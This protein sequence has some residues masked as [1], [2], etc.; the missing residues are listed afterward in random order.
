MAVTTIEDVD[1]VSGA[2]FQYELMKP[3][4]AI[5]TR[6]LLATDDKSRAYS[7]I[8]RFPI[9]RI[10]YR[11]T[12]YYYHWN[13]KVVLMSL[14][15]VGC[16]RLICVHWWS[17]RSRMCVDDHNLSFIACSVPVLLAEMLQS[18]RHNPHTVRYETSQNLLIIG[19]RSNRR[20]RCQP[21]WS[22]MAELRL[23]CGKKNIAHEYYST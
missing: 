9:Y 18:R 20:R 13:I 14:S 6:F 11:A 10:I 23:G 2:P 15:D 7:C 12:N 1:R 8:G 16:M 17:C 3:R 19:E 21:G 22:A 5:V 4:V